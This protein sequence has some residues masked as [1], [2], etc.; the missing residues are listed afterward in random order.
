MLKKRGQINLSRKRTVVFG[1]KEKKRFFQLGLCICLFLLVFVCRGNELF[2]K[3]QT[4]EKILQIVQE[5]TDFAAAFSNLGQSI[6]DGDIMRSGIKTFF[7]DLFGVEYIR[8]PEPMRIEI[9]K[10]AAFEQAVRGLSSQVTLTTMLKSLGV[11]SADVSYTPDLFAEDERT[12]NDL[13]AEGSDLPSDSVDTQEEAVICPVYEGPALP[14]NATMEYFALGL[15]S[16][17]TPVVGEISSGFGYRD[18][19]LTAEHSFHAGVDIAAKFGTPIAAFSDGIVE[20]IG[21]SDAY[22]LYIQLDHGNDIK[23]FYC[24]CSELLYGKGTPIVAGQTIAMVGDTGDVTGSHLHFELKKDGV[25]LN[26]SYY[27][28]VVC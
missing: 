17:V 1:E 22:G 21:E 13:M 6:S 15:S 28:E 25:L 23:T 2:L 9:A 14:S 27:I 10:G 20:F 18:H 5:N 16:T 24:H 4:G 12:E 11:E 7:N 19:P 8:E 26:P 3:R